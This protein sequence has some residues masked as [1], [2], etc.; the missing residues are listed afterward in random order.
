MTEEQADRMINLLE[1]IDGHLERLSDGD[2]FTDS[3]NDKLDA[4]GS[5]LDEINSSI[6]SI[7]SG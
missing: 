1:K 6:G 3:I 2:W 5:K 4:L 7:G